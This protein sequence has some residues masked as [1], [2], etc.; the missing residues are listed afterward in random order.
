[1]DS[2]VVK[3]GQPLK[4]E[5][6]A[7]G[8]KNAALPIL[9]ACLLTN[10]EVHLTNVPAIRDVDAMLTIMSDLGVS[11]RH[12]GPNEIVVHAKECT[13]TELRPDI[14]S[15]IRASLLLA[16]PLLARCGRVTL[17]RPGGDLIG[18]RRID[19]H[20]LALEGLGARCEV[21]HKSYTMVTD[22][23]LRGDDIF[24]D[25]MSVTATENAI[26][27]A[28]CAR[29]TTIVRNAASEP[30]IQDLIS[31]LQSLGAHVDGAGSNMLTI[32]GIDGLGGGSYRI[33]P[34]HT[35]VASF[36]ALAAASH[37]EI[38]IKDTAPDHLRMTLMVFRKLG[39]HV[40]I[41][42]NDIFVPRH[43]RLDVVFDAHGAIPKIDDGPWPAFPTDMMSVTIVLATQ[44][45]GTVLIWEKMFEGR[46]IFVDKLLAMGARLVLCDPY[47][48]VVVGPSAL[49]GEE[50]VS[51]DIRAGVALL[52]A[53]LCAEGTSV[54]RNV[55]QID[56][57]YEQIEQRLSALGAQIERR[58]E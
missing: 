40:E 46:M 24:L 39:V 52:I 30:H 31:F 29:G 48:V 42:G 2:F 33:Q 25:E 7:A 57:G 43:D 32:H 19:T 18:R 11:I 56:R 13:K 3:G 23:G 36:I 44:A 4:G 38:T 20:L 55:G 15:T 5:I 27:A 47:R 53:A 9:A 45:E 35:E 17:P 58:H 54:I 1:M 34:D 21:N 12:L 26:M 10:Q 28:A 49:H 22:R 8:N 16:G 51:P 6:R 14:A 50:M 37:S 41:R